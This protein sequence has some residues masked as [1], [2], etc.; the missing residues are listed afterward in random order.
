MRGIG[1]REVF[2]LFLG[3]TFY[4]FVNCSELLTYGWIA[5]LRIRDVYLG[6]EFFPSRIQC[7]KVSRI[8]IRIKKLSILTQKWFLSSRKH[9]LG[10]SFRIRILI[11]LPIPDPVVKKAPDPGYG[12]ATLLGIDHKNLNYMKNEFSFPLRTM[13]LT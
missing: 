9:D 2:I 7:Q 5:V 1:E 3:T 6:S 11:I 8:R 13:I 12:S 10:C 4:V